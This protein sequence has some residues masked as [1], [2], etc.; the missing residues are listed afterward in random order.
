MFEALLVLL[1]TVFA[2]KKVITGCPQA[3]IP[4]PVVL[5]VSLRLGQYL[6]PPLSVRPTGG[7]PPCLL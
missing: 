5:Y 3:I 1:Q 2:Q 4:A 7:L 6:P